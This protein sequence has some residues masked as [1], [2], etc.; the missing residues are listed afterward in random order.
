MTE[1][2]PE[3]KEQ[4]FDA[5]L[6]MAPQYA[7]LSFLARAVNEALGLAWTDAAWRGLM[8]RNPSTKA[9]L[10][11]TL[12]TAQ[13]T[14]SAVHRVTGDVRGIVFSDIHAPFHDPQ[15]IALAAQIAKWWKPNVAIWNGDDLD[16]YR[17]S[18]YSK[19]PDRTERIQ[20]EIDAWHIEAMAPLLSALLP[21]PRTASPEQSMVAAEV[22]TCRKYKTRGN[23][24]ARLQA[25][26]WENPGLFGIPSLDLPNLLE[27]GRLGIEYASLKVLF[28]DVLEVSHGTSVRPLAGASA[29]AESEKRRYGISTITGHVHRAGYFTTR[30]A[31]GWV[32][33]QEAPCLCKLDPEYMQD[34]DWVDWVQGVTLFEIRNG[35]LRID[36]V[37]FFADYTALVGKQYFQA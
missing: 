23:H 35:K 20:D 21:S 31:R 28:D 13:R 33:A 26:L 3:V 10:L 12:G 19:N 2:A 9:R 6:R 16:F 7:R 22:G 24:E 25:S 18:R 30:T 36:V 27:L 37:E 8:K 29:K 5:A 11:K 15:A 17:L 4:V 32:K 14:H 1:I 34:P